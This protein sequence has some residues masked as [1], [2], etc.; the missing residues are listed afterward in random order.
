MRRPFP[1]QSLFQQSVTKDVEESQAE[2]T[3]V[4]RLELILFLMLSSWLLDEPTFDLDPTN[5]YM[6]VKDRLLS[7]FD[8]LLFLSRG[9]TVYKGSLV[10][11]LSFFSNSA[12]QFLIKRI[13]GTSR[14]RA[15]SEVG[16]D[17]RVMWS[18]I[19]TSWS[20][21]GQ[22]RIRGHIGELGDVEVQSA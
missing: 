1:A 19:S 5:A 20:K 15:E 14:Q 3:V 18:K 11:L 4:F 10:N 21:R 9:Q 13:S 12:I 8:R 6:V 22:V 2:N 7:L 17:P 16:R